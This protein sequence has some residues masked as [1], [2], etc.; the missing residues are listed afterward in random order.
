MES[1]VLSRL[2]ADL[3]LHQ[4]TQGFQMKDNPAFINLI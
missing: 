2:S 1:K 3:N 4:N